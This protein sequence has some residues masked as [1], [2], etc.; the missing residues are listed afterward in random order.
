LF[1]I[2][3][4]INEWLLEMGM[5]VIFSPK[6]FEGNGPGHVFSGAAVWVML[7][8]SK[9]LQDIQK[10]LQERRKA[11]VYQITDLNCSP[12]SSNDQSS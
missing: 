9:T 1:H 10:D 12:G 6:R 3:D 4:S 11:S 7:M 2:I 5:N 8:E